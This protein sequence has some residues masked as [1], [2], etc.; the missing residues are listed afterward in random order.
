M[1]TDLRDEFDLI[2]MGA[3]HSLP[4]HHGSLGRTP[5][6]KDLRESHLFA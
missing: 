5:Y 2:V 3:R 6:P 1:S 4:T